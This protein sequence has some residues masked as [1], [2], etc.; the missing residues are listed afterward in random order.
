M[1]SFVKHARHS[2]D[3]GTPSGLAPG[4]REYL[5]TTSPLRELAIPFTGERRASAPHEPFPYQNSLA[6]GDP[7]SMLGNQIL[8]Q[9]PGVEGE[10]ESAR[11]GARIGRL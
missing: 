5:L 3:P 7:V 1:V 10:T 9:T 8:S 11:A 6:W 4:D 2:T